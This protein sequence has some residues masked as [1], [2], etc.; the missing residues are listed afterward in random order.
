MSAVLPVQA[1]VRVFVTSPVTKRCP[2][3]D[4]VDVGEV[5]LSWDTSDGETL[6][7]HGLRALIDGYED[8][9]ISHEEFAHELG[10]DVFA[11]T[12]KRVYVTAAWET[13]GMQV[14]V[15]A[16]PDYRGV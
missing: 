15:N 8:R 16:L 9:A 7:L 5:S 11:A 2:V 3:V 12:G 6:E 10:D 4:E 1:R 13:A 14:K